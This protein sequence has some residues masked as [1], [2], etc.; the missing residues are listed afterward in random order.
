MRLRLLEGTSGEVADHPVSMVH[1]TPEPAARSGKTEFGS[2]M[3]ITESSTGQQLTIILKTDGAP[4]KEAPRF[5]WATA[6]RV[7]RVSGYSGI[8]V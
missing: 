2:L 3:P 6:H 1:A 4:W 8:T 7:G 5:S